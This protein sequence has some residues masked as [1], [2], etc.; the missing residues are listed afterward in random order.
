V[1]RCE[2][3]LCSGSAFYRSRRVGERAPE[4]VELDRRPL[5]TGGS[6]V[7]WGG[8]RRG[9]DKSAVP[10]HLLRLG[11]GEEGAWEE[12]WR[13][14]GGGEARPWKRR[15]VGRRSGTTL[16]GGSRRSA[17]EG[18]RRGRWAAG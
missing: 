11:G 12:E 5:V 16:T 9:G 7:E 13:R 18:G 14:E 6:G 17:T 1:E 8:F 4:A 3:K 2:L 10:T 15:S